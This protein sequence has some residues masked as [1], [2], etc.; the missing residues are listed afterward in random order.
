MRYAG[1][2]TYKHDDALTLRVG[3]AFD[4]TPV[5]RAILRTARIP[6]ADRTWI[7]IGATYQVNQNLSVDAGFAHLFIDD[8]TL[9]NTELDTGHTLVGSFDAEFNIVSVQAGYRF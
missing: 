8:P 7:T 5:P 6:D 4:E 1:G 2:V 3:A 9:S